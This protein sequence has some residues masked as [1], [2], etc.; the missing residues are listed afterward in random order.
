ME[1]MSRRRLMATSVTAAVAAAILG[2]GVAAAQTSPPK[3]VRWLL[4]FDVAFDA[5]TLD[6]TR[7]PGTGGAPVPGPIYLAGPIYDGGGLG[8]DGRP[9]SDAVQRG[10][11]RFFGWLVNPAGAPLV[12][13]NHSFD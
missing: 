8:Q 3:I 5:R 2:N 7:A 9:T 11:H 13:G 1:R 10:Y 12:I 6:T 4:D